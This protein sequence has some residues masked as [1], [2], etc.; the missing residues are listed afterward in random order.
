MCFLD[1]VVLISSSW[2]WK[3]SK[4][5]LPALAFPTLLVLSP[6][7]LG[8]LQRSDSV[9]RFSY[10]LFDAVATWIFSELFICWKIVHYV[11]KSPNPTKL[12]TCALKYKCSSKWLIT[13]FL[14]VILDYLRNPPP[15]GV[16]LFREL[17]PKRFFRQDINSLKA[18]SKLF[19]V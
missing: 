8:S 1:G 2:D 16:T 6:R 15:Q 7:F 12:C 18:Q 17:L 14:S 9:P 5:L 13:L 11:L 4:C 19:I 10:N 3:Y